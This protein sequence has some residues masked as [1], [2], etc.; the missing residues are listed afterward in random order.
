M[1]LGRELSSVVFAQS[2]LTW[3]MAKYLEAPGLCL[4][5]RSSQLSSGCR[6][7][8]QYHRFLLPQRY[9]FLP[10]LGGSSKPFGK[11]ATSGKSRNFFPPWKYC[12]KMSHP[13]KKC[14]KEFGKPGWV[15]LAAGVKSRS[16]PLNVFA[17]LIPVAPATAAT[18]SDNFKTTVSPAELSYLHA[19]CA[20][21]MHT[22]PL[23]FMSLASLANRLASYA[24]GDTPTPGTSA[25]ITSHD[26]SWVIDLGASTHMTGTPSILPIIL[27]PLFP[28]STLSMVAHVRSVVLVPPELQPPCH[29][30]MSFTS[31]DFPQ[32]FYPS[33]L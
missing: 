25:L 8:C 7:I 2:L 33:V 6:T 14:W 19:S 30:I 15:L 31:L 26:I 28:T 18:P 4:P 5:R 1:S 23:A 10:P 16:A 22:L 24:G 21:T 12:R 3:Y 20:S 11:G 9:L 27:T 32:N 17:P 29:Y 13:D